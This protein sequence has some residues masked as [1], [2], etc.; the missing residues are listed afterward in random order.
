M[1]VISVIAAV[2][3]VVLLYCSIIFTNIKGFDK[4]K[5]FL[6]IAPITL[7][8][9][10]LCKT[11]GV[12]VGLAI[13]FVMAMLFS[14]FTSFAV[15]N[16]KDRAFGLVSLITFVVSLVMFITFVSSSSENNYYDDT[17]TYS[18]KPQITHECYVCGD[19]ATL[20]YGS[21]YYCNTH[22]AMVKTV[23]EAD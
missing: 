22:W 4:G 13:I 8:I 12:R 21:H 23:T 10:L 20:K 14:F 15:F 5:K 2:A 6:F 18:R 3:T 7:I 16:S 1:G 19:D 9:C 11:E 17:P